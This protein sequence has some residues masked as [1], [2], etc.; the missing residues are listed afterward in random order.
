VANKDDGRLLPCND[1]SRRRHIV[2]QRQRWVLDDA[3][4][5]T[6]I[7]Q[8]LVDTFP[9]RTVHE[10]TMDED[11][12]RGSAFSHDDLLSAKNAREERVGIL[13]SP[14]ACSQLKT[15]EV[16]AAIAARIGRC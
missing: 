8:D 7:P 1:P 4:V 11:D 5:V 10:A 3:H 6:V 14:D 15:R 13:R 12:R 2:E 16:I 9:T